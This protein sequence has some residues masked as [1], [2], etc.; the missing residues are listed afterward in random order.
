MW[1]LGSSDFCILLSVAFL[2][3][4]LKCRVFL[5]VATVVVFGNIILIRTCCMVRG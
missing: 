5:P 2:F 4:Y 1:R 3:D